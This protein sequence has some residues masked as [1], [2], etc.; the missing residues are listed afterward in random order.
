M[1]F[2]ACS[3][4]KM[5]FFFINKL[6]I[7][8]CWKLL[9]CNSVNNS[10]II[11]TCYLKSF[12][13]IFFF[14]FCNTV[15]LAGFWQLSYIWNKCHSKKCRSQRC[16]V[17]IKY[18]IYWSLLFL[19]REKLLFNLKPFLT[20]FNRDIIIFW[21]TATIFFCLRKNNTLLKTNSWKI[22]LILIFLDFQV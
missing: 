4:A 22:L 13:S 20:F 3:H 19:I 6:R 11:T 16:N 2:S 1:L 18:L 14:S 7:S 8:G 15:V 10:T 5:F 17:S 12:W 21:Q 9:K